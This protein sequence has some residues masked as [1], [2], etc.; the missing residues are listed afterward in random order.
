[1]SELGRQIDALIAAA[2]FA[3][4]AKGAHFRQARTGKP[5]CAFLCSQVRMGR[6]CA[7]RGARG[8]GFDCRQ[9]ADRFAAFHL[10]S[11]QVA[12]KTCRCARKPSRRSSAP[13]NWMRPC[14]RRWLYLAHQMSATGEHAAATEAWHR[15]APCWHVR[16]MRG[17]LRGADPCTRRRCGARGRSVSR[18]LVR[19]T[20]SSR[21][22]ARHGRIGCR[23]VRFR[24][25]QGLSSTLVGETAG[26][27]G[28][29][30]LLGFV[31]GEL[32]EDRLARDALQAQSST[33]PS[34]SRRARGAVFAASHRIRR[35][36]CC[37]ARTLCRRVGARWRTMPIGSRAS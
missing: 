28:A 18:G 2:K 30:N 11:A 26:D 10:L 4:Q 12:I 36:H 16:R 35:A 7:G 20:E 32:G 17:Y 22:V 25:R 9:R 37:V 3:W 19:S 14:P 24:Y 13:S 29:L 21:C 5:R 34:V 8:A 23:N 27:E 31:H 1:M 15:Y 6:R 33:V